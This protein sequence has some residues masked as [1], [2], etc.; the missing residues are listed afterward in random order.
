MPVSKRAFFAR[1]NEDPAEELRVLLDHST[2]PLEFTP[3]VFPA[4]RRPE[5]DSRTSQEASCLLY[6]SRCIPRPRACK[7]VSDI[8]T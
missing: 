7:A 4:T 6:T 8:V 5:P 2:Y 1:L 3:D